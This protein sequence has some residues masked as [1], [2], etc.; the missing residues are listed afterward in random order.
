MNGK[1]LV[2]H[3]AGGMTETPLDRVPNLT[4]LQ[5]AVGGFIEPV[6]SFTSIARDGA[7]VDCI[8]FCNEEGKLQRL[9]VNRNATRLWDEALRR[10]KT[11]RGAPAYP[12]GLTGRDGKPVDLLVGNVCVIVGDAELLGAL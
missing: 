11:D 6:P 1:A 2:F 10:I 12:T 9:E 4:F 8:A 5:K 7:V 3:P